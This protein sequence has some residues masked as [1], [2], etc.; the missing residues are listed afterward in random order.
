MK[1]TVLLKNG[2][3]GGVLILGLLPWPPFIVNWLPFWGVLLIVTWLYVQPESLKFHTIFFFGLLVDAFNGGVLGGHA[4]SYIFIA[5]LFYQIRF[6]FNFYP[7][8]QQSGLIALFAL[9]HSSVLFGIQNIFIAPHQ[10]WYLSGSLVTTTLAWFVIS[11]FL[12][13]KRGYLTNI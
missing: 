10:S 7:V 5:M 9:F 3:L 12:K 8:W 13:H 11:F 6:R 2:L 1:Q 4:L